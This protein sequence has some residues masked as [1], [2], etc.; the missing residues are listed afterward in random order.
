M[1]LAFSSIFLGRRRQWQFL[2]DFLQPDCGHGHH[3]RR[4][5]RRL[6]PGALHCAGQRCTEPLSLRRST[7]KSLFWADYYSEMTACPGLETESFC[8]KVKDCRAPVQ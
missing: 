3:Q 4:G 1:L 2:M 7:G 6:G 5:D 8:L